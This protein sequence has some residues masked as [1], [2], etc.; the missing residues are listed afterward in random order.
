MGLLD[1]EVCRLARK[2]FGVLT[3]TDLISA[4]RSAEA[5]RRAVER[6]EL[7]TVHEGIHR[8]AGAPVTWE[9][10]VLLAVL[11]AGPGALASHR[12]AAALWDLDGSTQGVPEIVAPRHRR[13]WA[14]ELGRSHESTDLHL[15]EPTERLAIPCTGLVRTLVDLGAVVSPERLQQAID[16]GIRRNLCTWED[17][18]HAMARHSRRGRR[19]VGP[20]RAILEE[21]Y[22][23]NVPDSRFNRL[24]ERLLI[25]SGQPAPEI[26]HR[27]F[28]Q[29][30]EELARLDLA[31]PDRLVGLELDSRQHH[32]SAPAFEA[33][34]VRQN[35][36]EVR[37]WMVLRY[38]WRH[39]TRTPNRIVADVDAAL[40]L[41]AP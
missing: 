25:E 34:R 27:V 11:A 22:G 30:G 14:T 12:S 18:L 24:V 19:G 20:L 1:H 31:Y 16:D 9:Q 2:R 32:L 15:A 28:D 4:G 33:D 36:L 6:G 7:E 26:E 3:T 21:C 8:V 41:R 23:T 5:V 40:R 29:G 39:Y 38:T 35:R 13:T 37:G 10:R 17:L